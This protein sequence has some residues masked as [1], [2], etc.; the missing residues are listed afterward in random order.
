MIHTD[1]HLHFCAAPRLDELLTYCGTGGIGRAGLVSLPDRKAGNFN[2][3]VINAVKHNPARFIGFG[4]LDH[5][6]QRSETGGAAQVKELFSE[7]FTGL[8]LWLGKP[9]TQV[10]F[11]VRMEDSYITGALKKCEELGLP[12]LLHLA[13][14][15]PFWEPGGPYG[16]KST[17]DRTDG[18]NHFGTFN[19]WIDRGREL[20]TKFPDVAF[21]GAHLLFLAGGMEKINEVM[22]CHPNLLLDTAPGRWFYR[23]LINHKSQAETFFE[24]YGTRILLGSD[25]MFF[26]E[27]FTLFPKMGVDENLESFNRIKSFLSGSTRK[28]EGE[29]NDPF[30][31]PDYSVEMKIPCLNLTEKTRELIMI[32]NADIFFKGV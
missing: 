18:I 6:Q 30:P 3:A 4:C 20:F 2:K 32:K 14:P 8:K 22:A 29:V 26:P 1:I 11:Q 25:A 28:G 27:E 16:S 13:D 21:L 31:W 12:V 19:D 9:R 10:D 23:I 5:R 17:A 7:G 15:P 24:K